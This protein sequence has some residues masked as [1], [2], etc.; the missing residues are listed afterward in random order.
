MIMEYSL[1]EACENPYLTP[2]FLV[3]STENIRG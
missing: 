2:A 3:R 1:T